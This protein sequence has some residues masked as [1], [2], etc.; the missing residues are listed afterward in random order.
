[1][2]DLIKELEIIENLMEILELKRCKMWNDK[3]KV[4]ISLEGLNTMAKPAWELGNWCVDRGAEQE[5]SHKE[6][7][8]L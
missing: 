7:N 1:M 5:G 6:D 8:L 4:I 2:E 3:S